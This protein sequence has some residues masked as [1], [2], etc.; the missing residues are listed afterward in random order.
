MAARGKTVRGQDAWLRFADEAGQVLRP[1]RARTW[2]RRGHPPRVTV[3]AAG[4]G[5]ISLAALVCRRPGHRTRLVFRMLVH[6]GRKSEKKGFRERDF[7]LLLEAAHQQLGGPIVLVWDNYTHHVD[8][9]MRELIGRRSAW[10]T[11]FRFPSYSPDLNPAEGVWAHLKRSLGNLAP[12]STDELA[13]LVRTRLKRMQ[14]RSGL[15]DG[16]IAETGLIAG[17]P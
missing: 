9:T 2:S 5:R 16:F 11:V 13:G 7:A 15:L 17:Q 8:A 6:H 4:S 1:P 12:C 10:L 3:R 14:Y